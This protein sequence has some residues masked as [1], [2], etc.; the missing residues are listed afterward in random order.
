[1]HI[2]TC[3]RA[4]AFLLLVTSVCA[5]GLAY[6]QAW[7]PLRGEGDYSVVFQDLYTR[8]HLLQDGSRIDGVNSGD[9]IVR[10]QLF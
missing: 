3:S 2:V 10:V 1:M 8:D 6:G 4:R 7:T 9:R 5:P